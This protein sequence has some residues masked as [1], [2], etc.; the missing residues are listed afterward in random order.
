LKDLFKY[1]TVNEYFWFPF[2]KEAS[3]GKHGTTSSTAAPWLREGLMAAGFFS[4]FFFAGGK[5][6]VAPLA[7]STSESHVTRP[8]DPTDVLNAFFGKLSVGAT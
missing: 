2:P 5:Q 7:F 8:D 6:N 1:L 3:E 4:S